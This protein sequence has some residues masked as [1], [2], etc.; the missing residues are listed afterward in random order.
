MYRNVYAGTFLTGGG[1]FNAP[2]S[3]LENP[4]KFMTYLREDVDNKK[5]YELQTL[6]GEEKLVYDFNLNVGNTIPKNLLLPHNTNYSDPNY[7]IITQITTANIFGKTVKVF[8]I[9]F[10]TGSQGQ[11]DEFLYVIEGIGNKT[12][13]LKLPDSNKIFEFG[14]LLD[15]FETVADGKNCDRTILL[16]TDNTA[17]KLDAELIYSRASADFRIFGKAKNYT[18]VFYDANGRKIETVENIG[19]NAEFRLNNKMQAQVLYYFI[20]SENKQKVGK[21]II[22]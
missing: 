5:I 10:I 17:I 16:N 9:Y 18:V 14:S 15:C 6:N 11:P 4:D 8:K 3:P 19:N 7:G 21:I 1:P 2:Y 13:L 22:P 20:R 12:S